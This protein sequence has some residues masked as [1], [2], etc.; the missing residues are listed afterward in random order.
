MNPDIDT[1]TAHLIKELTENQARFQQHNGIDFLIGPSHIVAKALATNHLPSPPRVK[2]QITLSDLGELHLYLGELLSTKS[3]PYPVIF[4]DHAELK[5]TL[6]PEY[7]LAEKLSWLDHSATVRLAHSREFNAW[8]VKDGVRMSQVEFAEFI[9]RNVIDITNP[10]GATMLTMAQTLEAT[11][12][13]VFKSAVRVSDG[14]HKFTWAND[15]ADN[16][17]NTEVPERFSLALR[18]FQGDEEAVEVTAKLYYRIKE[19]ALTFFYQLH[20]IDEIIEK[21]WDE[22]LIKLREA[23]GAQARV[24]AGAFAHSNITE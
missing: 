8:K 13:E 3:A 9:D 14:T 11:R 21:L 17:G 16:K 23:L 5:F 6:F 2:R 4:A 22:K 24:F 19:G 10:T 15:A 1:P 20:R 18:I 12:T 7:H